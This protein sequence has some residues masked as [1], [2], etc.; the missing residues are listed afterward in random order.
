MLT[1]DLVTVQLQRT[2]RAFPKLNFKRDVPDIDSFTA[3]DFEVQGYEP[4][5]SI[6][7]QMSV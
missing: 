5:P 4:H 6:K 2:P 3:E 1:R 7:M